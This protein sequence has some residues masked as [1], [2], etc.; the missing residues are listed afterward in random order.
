[1][2][3]NNRSCQFPEYY[4]VNN[5][6]ST[7]IRMP[8]RH[9]DHGCKNRDTICFKKVWYRLQKSIRCIS[10]ECVLEVSLPYRYLFGCKYH[11]GCCTVFHL[12]FICTIKCFNFSP[13][14]ITP[15]NFSHPISPPNRPQ[16]TVAPNSPPNN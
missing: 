4:D 15:P 11:F 2:M 3:S 16:V 14:P 6:R 12:H 13:Y 9:Y 8:M 7:Q 1:M 10:S 5:A